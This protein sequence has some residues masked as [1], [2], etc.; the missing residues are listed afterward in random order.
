MRITNNMLVNNMMRNLNRNLKKMDRI[1]Q[2]L[3]SGKKFQLPSQDPIGVSRSLKLHTD[4]SKIDQYKRN[5]DDANS[6]LDITESALSE[7]GDVLQRARELTVQ[8]SNGTNTEEDLEKIASEIKQLKDHLINVANTTYAGRYVF[9]GFKTDVPLLDENGNYKLTNY[10]NTYTINPS[11][12]T[13]TGNTVSKF[14]FSNDN[15]KI[16]IKEGTNTDVITLDSDYTD[17]T[18][19]ITEMNNQIS[20]TS[21]NVTNNA[22]SLE[23]TGT[24]AIEIVQVSGNIEDIGLDYTMDNIAANRSIK[25]SEIMRYNV[26]ISD[27]VDVNTVGTRVFGIFD[28]DYSD[29]NFDE[30]ATGYRENSD[31][32]AADKGDADKSYLIQI[33]DDL[34]GALES[35]DSDVIEE[36]L[37]RIDKAN[38]NLLSVRAD[39]G[40]KVNRLELTQKRLESAEINFTK[41]LAENEDADLSEVIMD[42]KMKENVYRAS[43][44]AGARIIQPTLVDFLR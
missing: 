27:Q 42:L 4:I 33:F 17:M 11:I 20:N 38:N 35:N 21:V 9:S 29:G 14:D 5:L 13:I 28:G 36:T 7:I 31:K 18:G 3:S 43:L 6:W 15:L 34:I 37:G 40:A 26:G 25:Q 30:I 2:K 1:Q 22:G 41:L 16:Q 39:I 8:A 12:T 19:L 24:S 23:F 32:K 44:A 10:E